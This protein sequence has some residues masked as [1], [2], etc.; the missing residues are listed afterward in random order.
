MASQKIK[1]RKKTESLYVGTHKGYTALLNRET[2]GGL[3][4]V[5]IYDATDRVTHSSR[6]ADIPQ[7]KAAVVK[8][9]RI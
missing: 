6:V 8:A 1:W 7:A 2:E 3:V 9:L 5:T 4:D